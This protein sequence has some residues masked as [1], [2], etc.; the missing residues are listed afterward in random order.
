MPENATEALVKL[1]PQLTRYAARQ[2]VEKAL[3]DAKVRGCAISV[4]VVD[5]HGA[6]V[7]FE[8]DDQAAGVTVQTAIEKACTAA[9]L[10][11][12]SKLFEDFINAGATSF[13]ST[14]DVTPLQG[15]VPVIVNNAVVGAVG[16]SGASG[17]E[18]NAIA[19]QAS[20]LERAGRMHV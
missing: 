1:Q 2:I 18:D 15:G 17:E 8:R 3:S 14:P 16:V 19:N 7:A 4:A 10:R 11:D 20:Q 13:L 6:L 5:T 9:L 12:P